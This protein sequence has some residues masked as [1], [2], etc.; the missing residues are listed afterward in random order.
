V[1]PLF[2]ALPFALTSILS[3]KKKKKNYGKLKYFTMPKYNLQKNSSKTNQ[4]P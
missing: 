1:S 4:N 2:F 3:Q